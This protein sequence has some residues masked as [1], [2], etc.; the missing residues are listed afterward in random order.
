[1]VV[2]CFVWYVN[3]QNKQSYLI[4]K[5]SLLNNG[6]DLATARNLSKR[7]GTQAIEDLITKMQ[8]LQ[9]N[10]FDPSR[11]VVD[12]KGKSELVF[13]SASEDADKAN[14]RVVVSVE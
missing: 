10:G 7:N 5:I 13:L 11:L 3:S 14:R 12:G 4:R 2:G 1:M 9:Q 6:W 8:S